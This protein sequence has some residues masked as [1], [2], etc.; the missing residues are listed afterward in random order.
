MRSGKNNFVHLYYQLMEKALARSMC[1]TKFLIERDCLSAS[2][3]RLGNGFMPPSAISEARHH[4]ENI[5]QLM[6][7]M[8]SYAPPS[9]R[10]MEDKDLSLSSGRLQ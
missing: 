7:Q 9:R 2:M 5:N 4:L 1:F 8:E 6:K 3:T 10:L